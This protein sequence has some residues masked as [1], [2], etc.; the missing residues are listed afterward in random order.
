M[1]CARIYSKQDVSDLLQQSEGRVLAGKTEAGHCLRLHVGQSG[2]EISDRLQG[3]ELTSSSSK[4]IIMDATGKIAP[5]TTVR[6]IWRDINTR[7]GNPFENT[8][9][10]KYAYETQFEKGI[11]PASGAFLDRQQA[12]VLIRY[13]LNSPAGQAEL[14]KLDAGRAT[15][16]S[17]TQSVGRVE[18]IDGAW[19]MNAASRQN[20]VTHLADVTTVTLVIDLLAVD[21]I[22]LQT[23]YPSA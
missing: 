6:A 21:Q 12:L 1:P 3:Q 5:E 19:K 13:A 22:H 9:A 11:A 20:D 16:V 10:L 8:K 18:L 4:P 23:A 15:R 2:L 14:A 7:Q 17:T